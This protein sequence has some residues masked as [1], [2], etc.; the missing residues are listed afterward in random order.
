MAHSAQPTTPCS[1]TW[2]WAEIGLPPAEVNRCRE[3]FP[4]QY[5]KLSAYD[6]R[7]GRQTTALS[8]LVN[9]PPEEPGFRLAR[10]EGPGRTVAYTI[11]P[12]ATD[13]PRGRRYGTD[14]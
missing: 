9:R 6:A 3:A 8:F 1:S 12:Y 5:V 7:L 4:D 13:R 11:H 2:R 14:A 10:Q